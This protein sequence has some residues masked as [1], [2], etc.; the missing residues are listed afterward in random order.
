M[1]ENQPSG[2][3]DENQPSGS[4]DTVARARAGIRAWV[5]AGGAVLLRAAPTAIV[6]AMTAAALAPVLVPL[7]VGTLGSIVVQQVLAQLGNLGAD[8]MADVLQDAVH[9]MRGEAK[10]TGV[11][12]ETVRNVLE[13]RLEQELAGP[14]AAAIRAEIMQ[15]IQAV[16][17]VDETLRAAYDS[18]IQGLGDHIGRAMHELSQTAFEFRMLRDD[19]LGA[20]TSIQRDTAFVRDAVQDHGDELRRLNL[21]IA[22]LRREVALSGPATEGQGAEPILAEAALATM[23]EGLHP[24][25]GLPAFNETD[26]AWFFGRER[27][28]AM[29]IDRLRD[30]LR[31][32]SPL[33]VEGASG[34]GKSSVLRAG[35]IPELD[36]GGLAEPDS[37]HWP[38]EIMTPGPFPLRDLALRL[39]RRAELPASMV[40]DDIAAD[41]AST[42]LIIRQGLLDRGERRRRGVITTRPDLS[43]RR[44]PP[45]QSAGR[46]LII[47]IDQFEEVFTQCSDG[48]ER[49]RFIQA[50]CAAAAGSRRD[51][52]AAL[53]VIGLRAGFVEHCTAHPE[54]EPAL[55]DPL[56][57]GPMRPAELRDAIELPA[58]H[59]GLTVQAG[60]ADTMLRDLGAVEPPGDSDLA[61]YDPGRLPLLAHALRAT[62][63]RRTGG[64]LTIGDYSAAGGIK[65]A[66]AST[67]D[68]VY[69]SL[70][71]HGK[72][73]A[74]RLWEH[75]VSVRADAEDTRRRMSRAALIAELPP[76]D[77]VPAGLVLDRLEQERLVTA[78]QDTVQIAHEAL[79]RYWPKLAGWV[80]ENRAWRREQQS[81]IEHAREWEAGSRHPDRLL[82]GAALAAVHDGLNSARR[83]ELGELEA[84]F[85]SASETRQARA[86]RARTV[87][88]ATL[89]VLVVLTAG[90]AL[91]AQ[92]NSVTARQQQ[93]IAQSRQLAAEASALS[94]IDPQISLLLSLQAFRVQPTYEA[95]SS[96][97][98]AQSG[99]FADRLPNRSGPVN[100][101]AYDPAMPTRL[102]SAGQNDRVTIWNTATRTAVATLVGSSP[103][104][105]VAFDKQGRY[106]AG[107]EQNGTTV[108]WNARSLRE[109]G[110]VSQ[111]SDA[112]DT[113]AFSPDGGTFATAGDDG[114]V[115]LWSTR[116]LRKAGSYLV[117]N[118]TISG[119]AF[120]GDGNWL[121]AACADHDIRLWDLH[122]PTTTPPKLLRG[123]TELVRAV[124][125]S[126]DS[127]MLAS[128]SDDGTVRLWDLR[129]RNQLGVLT[130][131]GAQVRA[132][133]FNP[134]GTGL[135]AAGDDDVVRL[136]DVATR[137]Q[138][139]ALTGPAST[140]AGVAFSPDGTMLASADA[141]ASVGLWNIPSTSPGSTTVAAVAIAPSGGRLATSG[142]DGKVK[143]WDP[144]HYSRSFDLPPDAL[145]GPGEVGS[146][147]SSQDGLL[148]IPTAHGV[149]L[150]NIAGRRPAGML[151]APGAAVIAVAYRPGKPEVI[152][153]GLSND[154][155]DLWAPSAATPSGDYSVSGQVAPINAIAF[156]PDGSLLA[157]ASDDGTILLARVV[158]TGGRITA[159]VLVQLTGQLGRI[160][161]VAFSPDG[162]TL[163]SASTDGTVQLWDVSHPS[164][165]VALGPPLAGHTQAV[166]SV[167]FSGDGDLLAT[168]ADDDTIR[169]WDVRDPRA[170][171]PFATL[172]GLG[173]PTSVVFEPGSQKMAGAAADGS[174]LQWDTVAS[175]VAN[176]ICRSLP[177]D[178]IPDL[179]QYLLGVTPRPL[180]P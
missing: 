30:R 120:S 75:M 110:P 131:V 68:A 161:A 118:G 116:T 73:V 159:T 140:V 157:A 141:D 164:R 112:V 102:A 63:D 150:W 77:A 89:M 162:R 38:R 11:S 137:T 29:I 71:A 91:V 81:L 27:L 176:R 85:L 126:P 165:Q 174:L 47:V 90:T 67:A 180:C 79:L 94:T 59:A 25:P 134:D 106:L 127:S 13:R 158:V 167:A 57:V 113:V 136:W 3:M 166:I 17:G 145:G 60:L 32:S 83:A 74:R 36:T 43:A 107:A 129:T 114:T 138:V 103:F 168:S 22:L 92:A 151:S 56:I 2:S 156:S 19:T 172:A 144:P 64:E 121:A 55:A 33:I 175:D 58:R 130:G 51:P 7:L 10:V 170:P 173:G 125:F 155:V 26:A 119:I 16:H 99:F 115:T 80:E 1:D 65:D 28:I 12:E 9:R 4:E 111:H 154:V 123:H 5:T 143:V 97:L 42:P 44:D 149:A 178:D 54:L 117:G 147:A 53:V 34:A 8:H 135:A 148:A 163:A 160:E 105:A 169:L 96:L 177:V 82:R 87:F 133:A 146:T 50:I 171:V 48:G 37:E 23:R 41:P 21:N 95:V 31:G 88:V 40:L 72:Q 104:Y 93:A 45:G 139:S 101:V 69:E 78:G 142:T 14:R 100:S 62:W 128:G 84:A 66:L 24:Y 70:D 122:Q 152:A 132:V 61:T 98:S 179:G 6:T 124:A 18:E 46:R 109:I 39:A 153:A 20:L 76:A 49:A 52:P 35:L 86:Q 15:L 108:L